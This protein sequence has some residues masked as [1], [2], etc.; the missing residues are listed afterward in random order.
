VL[1][2]GYVGT[3]GNFLQRARQVNLN[4]TIPRPATDLADE[5]ARFRHFLRKP[6]REFDA[7]F[8]AAGPGVQFGEFLRQLGQ[9]EFPFAGGIGHASVPSRIFDA[10]G[11]HILQV[12]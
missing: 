4:A 10:A 8:L 12:D 3:K 1:K 7:V 9:L 2:A 5:A 11:L 6:D